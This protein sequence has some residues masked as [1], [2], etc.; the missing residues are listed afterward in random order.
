VD[1]SDGRRRCGNDGRHGE[2]AALCGVANGGGGWASVAT[3]GGRGYRGRRRATAV[4]GRAAVSRRWRSW[5]GWSVA[6]LGGGAGRARGGGRGRARGAWGG[7]GVG[8]AAT[9]GVGRA[10]AARRRTWAA[11][12]ISNRKR[13]KKDAPRRRLF[14]ITPVGQRTQPTGVT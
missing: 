1:D 14:R 10:R 8:W 11:A 4:G 12:V 9:G 5:A 6:G 2:A 3:E 13:K 7:R